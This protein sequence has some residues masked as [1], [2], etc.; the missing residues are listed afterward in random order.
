M[1]TKLLSFMVASM[2]AVSMNLCAQEAEE[3]AP[4]AAPEAAPEVVEEE[5]EASYSVGVDVDLFSA[6]VWRNA[7][8]NDHMVLQPCVW[9]EWTFLEPFSIGAFVWQNYDLTDH[10]RKGYLKH[11]YTETDYNLHLGVDVL[12]LVLSEESEI[13][14]T[15]SVNLELGHDWFTYHGARGDEDPDTHEFYLKAT[16]ENPV[17]TVYGQTSWMYHDRGPYETG[18]HYELGFN[19]E[20]ELTEALTLGADWNVGMADR[21]YNDFLYGVHHAGLT[22]TTVKLYSVLALTDWMS[23]QGTI[24]YTGVLNSDVRGDIN[25]DLDPED[26][27]Y[28]RDLL[29]GGVS[30]KLEF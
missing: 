16:I 30:L 7:V 4:E 9:G 6:Y 2:C 22:G 13:A 17:V 21:D 29:W 28:S 27:R 19:K 10:R 25:D 11:A 5:E 18:F 3:V 15:L 14:E 23:L 8:M 20:V 24:A 1:N 26:K 12:P